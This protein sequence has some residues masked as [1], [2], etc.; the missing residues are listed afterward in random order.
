MIP[1]EDKIVRFLQNI[2]TVEETEEVVRFLD[3][4]DNETEI[5]RTLGTIWQ[6]HEFSTKNGNMDLDTV[7]EKV[8]HRI[9]APV[10]TIPVCDKISLSINWM[11]VFYK[12]AAILFLPLLI[13]TIWSLSR[14]NAKVIPE[15][16]TWVELNTPMGAK[17]NFELPDGSKVWLND[18]SK[19]KYPTHFASSQREVFLEGEAFFEVAKNEKM[20]FILKNKSAT[21]KVT[22]TSFNI[23]AYPDE[24]LYEATLNSGTIELEIPETGVKASHKMV[25]K[26][27]EQIRLNTQNGKYEAKKVDAEAFN[28]WINGKLL[29]RDAPMDEVMRKLERWYNA[30][31]VINSPEL[32]NILITG[33]FQE[34]KLSQALELL[35]FAT[36]IKYSISNRKR[37]ED[38]SYTRQLIVISKR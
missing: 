26:P 23:R 4:T 34:E 29:F 36:P 11:S 6:N 32:K 28:A 3:Q 27:G 10:T 35:S 38:G 17:M 31:I 5:R 12:V 19:I 14:P 20:P 24:Q 7:L 30:D 33:T 22:G 15:Q 18:G 16:T 13:T 37:K 25:M 8:H 2:S 1:S 21:V 9:G